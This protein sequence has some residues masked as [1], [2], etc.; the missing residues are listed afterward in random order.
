MPDAE[1]RVEQAGRRAE[2]LVCIRLRYAI[3]TD[4]E[5]QGVTAPAVRGRGRGE[6]F[7]RFPSDLPTPVGDTHAP[8]QL[9][10]RP[11]LATPGGVCRRAQT[12]TG[13]APSNGILY[14]ASLA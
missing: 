8:T 10:V 5:D 11:R 7:D 6:R 9:A 4:L 1:P 3:D 14:S 13:G 12:P 2:R